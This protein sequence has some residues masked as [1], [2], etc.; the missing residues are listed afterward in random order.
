MNEE[1]CRYFYVYKPY[2]RRYSEQ[3]VHG[4]VF[5][6]RCEDHGVENKAFEKEQ[7][8]KNKKND[9][10][11]ADKISS[12][13]IY[14]VPEGHILTVPLRHF[15]FVRLCLFLRPLFPLPLRLAIS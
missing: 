7:Y 3:T 12:Q 15:S 8:K 11:R 1:L 4:K 10:N 9:K 2:L 14:M 13:F 5:A 6:Q